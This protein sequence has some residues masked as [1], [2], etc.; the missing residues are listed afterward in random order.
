MSA[1]HNRLFE[2]KNAK[3]LVGNI[4]TKNSLDFKL[5]IDTIYNVGIF[6]SKKLWL[7]SDQFLYPLEH[8]KRAQFDSA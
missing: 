1:E 2:V 3:I 5:S 4:V 7:I 6:G 8:Y